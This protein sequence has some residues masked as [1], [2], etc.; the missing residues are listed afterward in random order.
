[1]DEWTSFAG[2]WQQ[3]LRIIFCW[4]EA[5]EEVRKITIISEFSALF[6]SCAPSGARF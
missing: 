1:M 6:Y 2:K 4:Q 5:K 3:D